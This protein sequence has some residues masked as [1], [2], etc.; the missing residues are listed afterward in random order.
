MKK[1]IRKRERV[2][3][4]SAHDFSVN[5][6]IFQYCFDLGSLCPGNLIALKEF[7]VLKDQSPTNMYNGYIYLNKSVSEVS[8]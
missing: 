7:T 2:A 8:E 1:L 4:I 6:P 3:T 5:R